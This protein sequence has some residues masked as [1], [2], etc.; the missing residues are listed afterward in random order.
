MGN[1]G[2][3][4]N[5]PLLIPVDRRQFGRR[6]ANP[7]RFVWTRLRMCWGKPLSVQWGFDRGYPV[8]RH[9]ID[10]FLQEHAADIHGACLEFQDLLYVDRFGALA[11]GAVTRKDVLHLDRSNPHATI[12]ADITEPNCI[13]DNTY[14]CIVCTHVLHGIYDLDAAVACLWRILKPGGVLLV[15]VPQVSLAGAEYHELWRFTAM[16]VRVML[17]RAFGANHVQVR[18]YGNSIVSAGELRGMVLHEFTARELYTH[19]PATASEICARAVKVVE[20]SRSEF[21]SSEVDG[22]ACRLH[23]SGLPQP[24]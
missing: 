12:V 3:V 1:P 6:M 10:L 14:D 23:Q 11:G 20:P 9:Y 8:H 22:G 7:L 16:G 17:A 19:D 5:L 24:A 13:P 4:A 15:A 18:A 2:A 21:L